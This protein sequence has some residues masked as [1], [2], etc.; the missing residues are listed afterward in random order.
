M[1]TAVGY[2]SHEMYLLVIFF[3]IAVSTF[4]FGIFHN[5][6]F[7][8]GEVV[9]GIHGRNRLMGNSLLDIIVFGRNAGRNA[10]I[11]SKNTQSG[12]LTLSHIQKFEKELSEAGIETDI[13]SPALLPDYT[14]R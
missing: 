11:R 9:G 7:A 3:G 5:R 13:K 6:I 10:G 8:A 2:E 4:D 12:E 1:H 14:R